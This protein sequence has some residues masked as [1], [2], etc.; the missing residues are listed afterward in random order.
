MSACESLPA[1]LPLPLDRRSA[2]DRH[3]RGRLQEGSTRGSIPLRGANDDSLEDFWKSAVE[4][5]TNLKLT[6][7]SDKRVAIWSV[8]KLVRDAVDEEY[9]V[10][11]WKGAL[12]EQLAWRVADCTTAERPKLLATIPSWS[13][14]SIE[15]R[16]LIAERSEQR[17]RFYRVT[18]HA[19]NPLS[20]AIG[21]NDVRPGL[22]R[23]TSS[24]VQDMTKELELVEERRRKSSATSRQN[25]RPDF[26]TL[27]KDIQAGSQTDESTTLF[28][29]RT[30]S[31]QQMSLESR[32][33]ES[34]ERQATR[35][36]SQSNAPNDRDK[37]PNLRSKELPVQGYLHRGCLKWN[38][39]IGNWLLEIANGSDGH[40]EQIDGD[41]FPDTRPK[42][43]KE[44]VTF[45]IL[46][47]TKHP[48]QTTTVRWPEKPSATQEA[49]YTGHGLIL[50][51]SEKEEHYQRV[52]AL[53]IRH[54]SSRMW[55]HLQTTSQ[56]QTSTT[57]SSKTVPKTHFFL[58]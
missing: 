54:L 19:G 48:D 2:M 6:H 21:D 57:E 38:N 53:H 10:G 39:D 24:T 15:G 43:D 31:P 14:A 9:V 37:E 26:S 45:V 5:Y 8:A 18:D 36:I 34:K 7:Q 52:G 40:P 35:Q 13:W 29:R 4:D 27:T 55:Q 11:L 49:W 51:C 30:M 47:L 46:A 32:T 58:I 17:K 50:R 22:P 3:W 56:A 28:G 33:S 16:I 44:L 12:E 20:F 41:A 42:T 25:S 1:G 23:K